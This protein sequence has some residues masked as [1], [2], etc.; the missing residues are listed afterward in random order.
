VKMSEQKWRVK[1]VLRVGGKTETPS[2]IGK[3]VRMNEHDK[4]M[5]LDNRVAVISAF[6]SVPYYDGGG[7]R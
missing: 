6:A 4:R 2:K 3:V 1:T 5:A 7:A